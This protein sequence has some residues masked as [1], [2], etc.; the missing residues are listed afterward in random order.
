METLEFIFWGI[1]QEKQFKNLVR[2]SMINMMDFNW[3]LMKVQ[4]E[5]ILQKKVIQLGYI[6]SK[7]NY[8][9]MNLIKFLLIKKGKKRLVEH[10]NY[11]LMI[12]QSTFI[13]LKKKFQFFSRTQGQVKKAKN[14]AFNFLCQ[15]KN[16]SRLNMIHTYS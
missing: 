13:F 3:Q 7:Q 6:E 11:G 5:V 15:N 9:M 8:L 4:L 12:K 14:L 10:A 1:I 2:V 16:I